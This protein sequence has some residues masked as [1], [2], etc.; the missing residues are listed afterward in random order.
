VLFSVYVNQHANA[1]EDGA[2]TR[3]TL[4]EK[5]PRLVRVTIVCLSEP[6]GIEREVALSVMEKSAE[7]EFTV[8]VSVADLVR[9]PLVPVT[10]TG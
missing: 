6:T 3:V 10:V 4:P 7:A 5:P 1:L 8:T 9:L 2:A